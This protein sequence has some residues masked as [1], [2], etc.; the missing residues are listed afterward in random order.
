MKRAVEHRLCV[1]DA[2]SI[3]STMCTADVHG[4]AYHLHAHWRDIAQH[5]CARGPCSCK[6]LPSASPDFSLTF[7]R[8]RSKRVPC[9]DIQCRLRL[10]SSQDFSGFLGIARTGLVVTPWPWGLYV[11][12]HMGPCSLVG[13]RG[14]L[15]CAGRVRVRFTGSG[16]TTGM[17]VL[18]AARQ[19]ASRSGL[20]AITKG[21][22]VRTVLS[23]PVPTPPRHPGRENRAQS[24]QSPIP[25]RGARPADHCTQ[26][27]QPFSKQQLL[28]NKLVRHPGHV[29]QARESHC[30]DCARSEI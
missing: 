26:S 2:H 30:V 12:G 14:S 22:P 11:P 18:S 19:R 16:P 7:L 20:G 24:H 28:K 21:T 6:H 25:P 8:L 9:P 17:P 15:D 29:S 4:N 13:F 23:H 5:C 3:G 27:H 1:A 10:P